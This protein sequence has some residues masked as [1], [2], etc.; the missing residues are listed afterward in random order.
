MPVSE[1]ST[2]DEVKSVSVKCPYCSQLHTYSVRLTTVALVTLATPTTSKSV[3]VRFQCAEKGKGFKAN[4]TIESA[5]AVQD[6]EVAV[7]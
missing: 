6:I 4:V 1:F 7:K 2:E 5:Y 3:T